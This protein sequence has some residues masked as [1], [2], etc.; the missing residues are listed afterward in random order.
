MISE[1][2][3]MVEKADTI[4]KK[5]YLLRKYDSQTLRDILK[6]AFDES[7]EWLLPDGRPP[8]TPD[9]S[10]I[11]MSPDHL[12]NLSRELYIFCNKGLARVGPNYKQSQRNKKWIDILESIYPPEAEV[13]IEMV[14]GQF[15]AKSVNKQLVQAAFPGLVD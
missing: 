14:S 1:I 15:S 5:C 9:D 11:E 7:I 12:Y 13:L 2:F 10:P 4:E 8:F 6:G 3:E